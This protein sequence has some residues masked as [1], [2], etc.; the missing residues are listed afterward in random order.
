MNRFFRTAYATTLVYLFLS[1]IAALATGIGVPFLSFLCLYFGLLVALLPHAMPKQQGREALMAVLG[2]LLALLGFLPI[3]L[4]GGRAIHC[5]VHGLGMLAAAVFFRLL[6][7]RT[8]HNDFIAKFRFTLVVLLVLIAGLY[9]SLLLGTA[10]DI[11]QVR[12][13]HVSRAL[14]HLAP[15]VILLL[16]TGV[17]L[18]RGLRGLQGTMDEKTFNRRQLRD[19]LIYG[20]LV[21]VLFLV[22]PF[23]YLSRGLSFLWEDVVR[24]AMR[25]LAWAFERLLELLANKEPK[26]APPTP[27]ATPDPADYY[28]PLPAETVMEQEPTQYKIDDAGEE[29]LYRTILYIFLAALAAVLLAIL[30]V[31]A[32]K[33]LRRLR[34]RG[35]SGRGYPHE[36]RESLDRADG[37]GKAERPKKRGADPRIRIRYLYGQFLRY[38][39]R[40]PI[41]IEP[42]DTCGKI[43]EHTKK[44]LR[45]SD[46]DLAAFT[47]LYEQA[48]YHDGAAP[49][50][51]DAARMKKLLDKLK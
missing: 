42:A 28:L 8:T 39:R 2:V 47:A 19:L 29:T 16:M 31:E 50:E 34:D 1:L 5:I 35:T 12:K 36:I 26:F 18:L 25:F 51:Q 49:T 45:V 14:D 4:N 43:Q 24:P 30:V 15:L 20:S 10:E 21:S 41:R 3:L 13:E 7:Y 22:D 33:L 37:A 40:V 44:A 6:R 32:R 11:F 17:L 48:R 46:R 9:L 23:R 38:L 27:E